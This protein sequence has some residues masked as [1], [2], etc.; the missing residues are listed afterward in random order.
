M[1]TLVFWFG[2]SN[3]RPVVI[4]NF[5][6]AQQCTHIAA[7][8]ESVRRSQLKEEGIR[9]SIEQNAFTFVCIQKK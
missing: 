8:L 5:E 9:A 3:V 6:T 7:S 4:E 1:F 2:I